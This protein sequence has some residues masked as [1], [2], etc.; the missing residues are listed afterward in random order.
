MSEVTKTQPQFYI[1]S[2]HCP[3]NYVNTSIHIC[4][5]PLTSLCLETAFSSVFI[6][7]IE[8][9]MSFLQPSSKQIQKSQIDGVRILPDGADG[10]SV[11]QPG[12]DL[13]L[14]VQQ[15]LVK[16]ALELAVRL[17]VRVVRI[18]E[19]LFKLM[20]IFATI[21]WE[22]CT[23][24]DIWSAPNRYWIFHS[25]HF[26]CPPVMS[27]LWNNNKKKVTLNDHLCL[28][29]LTISRG[30]NLFIFLLDL[31]LT[32]RWWKMYYSSKGERNLSACCFISFNNKSSY[33]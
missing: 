33:Y 9:L 19:A 20:Y 3:F 27:D 10:Q 25:F 6:S 8:K 29:W 16:L 21:I 23:P 22:A 4:W 26:S 14:Y 13:T 15:E 7:H 2:V 28:L 11:A 18:W 30:L 12:S 24:F 17:C 31:W 1:L 32:G 5:C